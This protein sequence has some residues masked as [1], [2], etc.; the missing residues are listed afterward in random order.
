MAILEI[1]SD[2]IAP[3]R[4]TSLADQN[5]RERA[6]LQRLLRASIEVLGEDLM[7]VTEE[8][9]SW[10]D[11]KR[12]IDLLAL[13]RDA[14]L[15]VIEL[16]RTEDGGHMDLQA[17]R[18]AA[19]TSV[20][21]FDQV[22]DA[23][24]DYLEAASAGADI[25]AQDAI[26]GFLQW[27]EPDEEVFAQDVRIILASM[28]FSREI[29]TTVLWLNQKGLDVRCVR[30]TPY[31]HGNTVLLD[32]Q[33][34]IPLPE[35]EDYQTRVRQKE[36]SIATARTGPDRTRF[37]LL[38][39]GGRVPDLPKRHAMLQLF[40]YLASRGVEPSALAKHLGSR[41][42]ERTIRK[43]PGEISSA[44]VLADLQSHTGNTRGRFHPKRWFYGE[45][46]LIYFGG[47]TYVVSNQWGRHTER[48]LRNLATAFPQHSVEVVAIPSG[49]S[50]APSA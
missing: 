13:D 47:D 28:N 32:V 20:M 16:K 34:I 36:R 11:S 14:N 43:Y 27:E 30:L 35:A 44:A 15:V 12:R 10:A 1:M 18:Y 23:H 3:L 22:V 9:G 45:D 4:E 40:R 17:L 29:T 2:R 25:D 26:L 6:D 8:F 39:N 46:E 31:E 33:Q 42:L 49:G 50:T 19:M 24:R 41:K 7:I 5:I 37:T 21:T 38:L 48:Y